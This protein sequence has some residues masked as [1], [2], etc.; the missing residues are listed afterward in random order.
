M[1]ELNGWLRRNFFWLVT[2]IFLAGGLVAT[3]SLHLN[4]SDIHV[5]VADRERLVRIEAKLDALEQQLQQL[6]RDLN[7]SHTAP[8]DGTGK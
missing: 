7:R 1:A 4:A 3:W 5:S 8:E 2:V 6:Q